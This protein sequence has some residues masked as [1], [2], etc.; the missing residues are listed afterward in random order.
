MHSVLVPIKLGHLKQARPAQRIGQMQGAAARAWRLHRRGTS[1]RDRTRHG[2]V[3]SDSA[4]RFHDEAF[5]TKTK[6][7]SG[8]GSGL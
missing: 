8:N 2:S 3:C 4:E 6:P 1:E 5:E 7:G